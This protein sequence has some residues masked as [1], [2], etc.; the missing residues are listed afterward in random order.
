MNFNLVDIL[1]DAP[2]G[3]KLY[4]PY[5]GDVSFEGITSKEFPI[6]VSYGEDTDGKS[7]GT[8]YFSKEGKISDKN[9]ECMLFPSKKE[10][11]WDKFKVQKFNPKSLKPFD[12]VLVRDT[13]TDFWKPNFFFEFNDN[14]DYPYLVIGDS[15]NHC[16]PYN[17]E[18]KFLLGT[19]LNAPNF[20]NV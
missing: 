10:R 17:E 20:Y 14:T 12:K 5:F 6:L 3:T 1:K 13:C 18:T 15:Y 7:I 8:C 11:N 19:D 9:D 16:I 2:K 4:S